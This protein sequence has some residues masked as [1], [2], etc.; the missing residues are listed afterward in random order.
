VENQHAI[1]HDAIGVLP[2]RADR[3]VVNLHLRHALTAG[4]HEIAR[5]EVAFHWRRILRRLGASDYGEKKK[6]D[7]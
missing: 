6:E 5:D 3:A 2:R 1:P 7:D 4:E